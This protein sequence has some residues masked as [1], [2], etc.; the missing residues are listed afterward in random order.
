MT[1]DRIGIQLRHLSGA[2]VCSLTADPRFCGFSVSSARNDVEGSVE[3]E[4]GRNYQF[5]GLLA[6]QT[7]QYAT[8]GYLPIQPLLGSRLAEA[9]DTC[10]VSDGDV[11]ERRLWAA[12]QEEGKAGCPE[13]Q[14][15]SDGGSLQAGDAGRS[16]SRCF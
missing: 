8:K 10:P 16:L 7:T 9:I 5:I 14:R 15:K 6:R 3:N 11:P 2:M 1:F 13:N 4:E 12:G